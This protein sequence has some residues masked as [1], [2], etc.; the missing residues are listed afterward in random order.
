MYLKHWAAEF[1]WSTI[2]QYLISPSE[3]FMTVTLNSYSFGSLL[4]ALVSLETIPCP[5]MLL[6][7]FAFPPLPWGESQQHPSCWWSQMGFLK[8]SLSPAQQISQFSFCHDKNQAWAGYWHLLRAETT[9]KLWD[10]LLL[11]LSFEI[12]LQPPRYSNY[13]LLEHH[14]PEKSIKKA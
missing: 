12:L 5:Y 2:V 10:Q 13:N 8:A 6:C 9:D 3:K 7:K 11:T 14:F 1:W 4:P